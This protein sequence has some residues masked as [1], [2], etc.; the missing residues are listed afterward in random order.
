MALLKHDG[1]W[2]LECQRCGKRCRTERGMSHGLCR[3]CF[4]E[5]ERLDRENTEISTE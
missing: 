4:Y 2:W 3:K 5:L 1:R